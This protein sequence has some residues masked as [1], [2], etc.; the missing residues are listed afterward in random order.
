MTSSS[1][2][3]ALELQLT[4]RRLIAGAAALPG[5]AFLTGISNSS[6]LAA[7]AQTPA[8]GKF[9]FVLLGD[10]HFDRLKDHDLEWLAKDKPG[11]LRQI[12]NY[13]RLTTAVMPELFREISAVVQEALSGVRVVRAYGQEQASEYQEPGGPAHA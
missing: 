10:L 13:S 3:S 4:R 5:A 2:R 12:Q 9:S 6:L 8:A 1:N 11:D 7:P